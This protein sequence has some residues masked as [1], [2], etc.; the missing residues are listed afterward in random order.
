MPH[1]TSPKDGG[2]GRTGRIPGSGIPSPSLQRGLGQWGRRDGRDQDRLRPTRPQA[3]PA[4][5]QWRR[6]VAPAARPPL[7][8]LL[9]PPGD[10]PPADG[11]RWEWSAPIDPFAFYRRRRPVPQGPRR[12]RLGWATGCGGGGG[13]PRHRGVLSLSYR[14]RPP[15][16][17]GG[18]RRPPRR[19][20]RPR[21]QWRRRR[22]RPG[23]LLSRLSLR[24]VLPGVFD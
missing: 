22:S 1:P 20:P 5:R 3:P 9:G 16:V 12:A 4:P 7:A 17:V 15:V 6:R 21:R 13:P 10:G 23:P 18:P 8:R 19:R 2:G 11:A 14:P 24:L